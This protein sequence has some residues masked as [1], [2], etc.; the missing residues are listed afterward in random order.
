MR[1]K[2]KLADKLRRDYV[3]KRKKKLRSRLKDELKEI[4]SGLT[5]SGRYGRMFI[6]D[7]HLLARWIRRYTDIHVNIHT[8]DNGYDVTYSVIKIDSR[9]IN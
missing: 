1:K 9:R 8:G 2:I 7:S 4:K 6:S 5:R 3:K